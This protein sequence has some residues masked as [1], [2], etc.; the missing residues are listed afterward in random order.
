M[1]AIHAAVGV[2]TVD[3]PRSLADEL[4]GLELGFRP[5]LAAGKL[6]LVQAFEHPVRRLVDVVVREHVGLVAHRREVD[7][8]ACIF[9][10][11]DRLPQFPARVEVVGGAELE[12]GIVIAH[13]GVGRRDDG[14]CRQ[15]GE[16]CAADHPIPSDHVGVTGGGVTGGA[17]GGF[18]DALTPFE[19]R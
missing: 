13:V 2:L 7:V 15:R 12:V 16:E 17:A 8:V 14:E 5:V 10:R 6:R 4:L 3:R 19:I 18:F 11:T 9:R 1:S